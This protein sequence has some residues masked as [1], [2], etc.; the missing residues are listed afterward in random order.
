MTPSALPAVFALILTGLLG[1]TAAHSA[2]DDALRVNAVVAEQRSIREWVYGQGTA[3]SARREFL[4]F[5]VPGRVEWVRG[6]ADGDELKEGDI[7]RGP[8]PGERLGELL[9]HQDTRELDAEI[10]SARSVVREARQQ[11]VGAEAELARAEARAR[12]VDLDLDR[13]AALQRRQAISRAEYDVAAAAADE[14][15]AGVAAARAAVDAARAGIQ[16]ATARTRSLEVA[17]EKLH[18]YAPMDGVVASVNVSPGHYWSPSFLNT[19]SEEAVLRTVPIL[20]IDPT[21]L[22][23][24]VDLPSFDGSRVR[25]GQ[26]GFLLTAETAEQAAALGAGAGSIEELA[27]PAI[28]HAVSPM[29]SPQ[30]R[31]IR[32][33][34]RTSGPVG[35][36]RDGMHVSVWIVTNEKDDAVVLPRNTLVFRGVEPLVFVVDDTG[37]VERREVTLGIRSID[38]VE[39]LTG[40]KPGER[41]VTRGRNRLTQGMR[42]RVV[43]AMR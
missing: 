2:E 20:I 24:T 31:S 5:E 4:M 39:I 33:K 1:P 22:E 6:G 16:T 29:V 19:S 25:E 7:V 26:L 23:V 9:A 27:L 41:V 18:L 36:L 14:A 17:R 32:T 35:G 30:G 8:E 37:M 38:E 15:R 43:E 34:L 21:R 13:K 11:L 10:D 42:V 3:R 12:Q 40:L 28:V